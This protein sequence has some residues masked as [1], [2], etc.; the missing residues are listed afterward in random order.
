MCY[1]LYSLPFSTKDQRTEDELASTDV[2]GCTFQWPLTSGSALERYLEEAK[3]AAVHA[4]LFRQSFHK[5][6][7]I[8][9]KITYFRSVWYHSISVSP[10]Y[11]SGT[12]S[13]HFSSLC[14]QHKVGSLEDWV[15]YII[16]ILTTLWADVLLLSPSARCYPESSHMSAGK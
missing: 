6:K 1:K 12:L 3:V 5:R 8:S 10:G 7:A 9:W 4:I 16:F 15:L 11:C 14:R 13:Y 2:R